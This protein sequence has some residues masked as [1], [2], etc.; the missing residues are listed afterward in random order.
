M[1]AMHL[2]LHFLG[3]IDIRLDAEIA[4]ES[5]A[6]RLEALLAY[7]AVEADRAHRRE[8]LVGLLFP[9][10]PD[11]QAR[12]N[13]R[14]TLTRLRRD[15]TDHKADP[16]FLLVSRESVQFNLQSNHFLDVAAFAALLEGCAQHRSERDPECNDCLAQMA[17][18]V[19]LYRGPFL[20]GF[21]LDDSVAYEDWVLAKR[22]HFQQ[23]MLLALR[24]LADADERRGA[25]GPAADYVRRRLQIEPWEENAHRQLMRLLAFQ[26][27]RAAALQQYETLQVVLEEELGIAPVAETRALRD[28]IAAAGDRRIHNL[29]APNSAFV[30]RDAE[31]SI[32]H[33]YLVDTRKRLL[34]VTGPGGSGKTAL[35][36]KLGW[37]VA[38]RFLGPF[39]HGVYLVPLSSINAAQWQ[40]SPAPASFDPLATALA[41]ALDFSFSAERQPRAQLLHYLQDKSLLLIVDNAEHV[42]PILRPFLH[43]LM[44]GAPDLALLVTS[45][46]RLGMSEEWVLEIEGLSY[47]ANGRQTSALLPDIDQVHEH[48]TQY[49]AIILFE[50]L[51]RRLMPGFTLSVEEGNQKNRCPAAAAQRIVQLVQGLPLGIELAASWLRTLSCTEIAEEIANSLDFLT[52]DRYGGPDRHNSMRAVFDSSWQLLNEQER[53]A[54]RRLSVLQGPFDRQAASAVSGAS[55]A[56]LG[57]LV[58]YSLLHRLQNS[59]TGLGSGSYELLNVLRQF[60]AEQLAEQDEE[61]QVREKHAHYYLQ[62]LASKLADLEGRDQIPALTAI[63]RSIN[64]VRGAWQWAVSYQDFASLSGAMESLSLY[65][66]M[67]S[68][69]A[70]GAELFGAAAAAVAVEPSSPPVNTL[71]ARLRTRQGWFNFLLG[72]QQE[73][74]AQLAESVETLRRSNAPADL[75]YALSFTAAALSRLGR[76]NQAHQLA[77]EA[78]A[79]NERSQDAYGSAIANNVLS[80]IAFQQGHYNAARDCSEASLALER[81]IGNQ[82]SIGFSLAN[83]GRVEL[84]LGDHQRARH[85][86]RESLDIRRAFADKRG[87]ALCLRYLADTAVG[88]G[89]WSTAQDSLE[90]SLLLF[91]SIGSQD[92]TSATLSSLGRL[93]LNQEYRSVARDYFAEAWQIASQA[94]S[95]PRMLE[96]LSG[97][98]W[99]LASEH[100]ARSL[101]I[102]QAIDAHPAA[103]RTSR[104]QAVKL[105]QALGSADS[106]QTVS[107]SPEELS[108]GILDL[109]GDNILADLR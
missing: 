45:R 94:N 77:M 30:G 50:A 82:W 26:G 102:A 92:E 91:R 37:R 15:I 68:W 65:Y 61:R 66:Y 107:S 46:E 6:K 52:S 81:A 71:W 105:L 1:T 20:Q 75:A 86:F 53:Q 97:L 56:T 103:N 87:Q 73:G 9:E 35:A 60:A 49:Q 47:P 31:L 48:A 27:Q 85:Y 57:A 8:R 93:S 76:N 34:T 101:E 24:H 79:I 95:K 70:E 40:S 17:E 83:L 33:E 78:L 72:K 18:A 90:S 38:T 44:N 4:V 74:Q 51:G 88:L 59:S 55:L 80:Q 28:R 29:P 3:P 58:D 106:G 54:L 62:F 84:A 23:E 100:P 41:E 7:L 36:V 43:E 10:V 5:R 96:A 39:F 69:F 89:D 108:T 14:Q 32:L 104:E 2:S 42:L 98:A 22:Q 67:R 63:A 21:F 99:L 64:D 19:R 25:Y 13:L 16:P 11:E 109:L 12:T